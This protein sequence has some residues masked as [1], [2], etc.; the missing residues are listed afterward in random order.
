[1]TDSI[2]ASSANGGS[3]TGKNTVEG[4]PSDG[5]DPLDTQR[6]TMETMVFGLVYTVNKDKEDT[7]REFVVGRL[8]LEFLQLWLLI[9]PPCA[10]ISVE[11]HNKRRQHG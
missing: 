7:P 6:A 4:R 8:A 9:K 1:M 2:A 5:E 11:D 3:A 10:D